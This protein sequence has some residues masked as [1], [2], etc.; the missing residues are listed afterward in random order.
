MAEGPLDNFTGGP[1]GQPDAARE[2]ADDEIEETEVAEDD[3]A[4]EEETP[5]APAE[6]AEEEP[7]DS[8]EQRI[9]DRFMED[10]LSEL[11]EEDRPAAKALAQ[12][13]F[14][15]AQ[16]PMAQ[17]N[18]ELRAKLAEAEKRAAAIPTPGKPEEAPEEIVIPDP[19]EDITG[20]LEAT[21]EKKLAPTRKELEELREFKR[22]ESR[23]IRVAEEHVA[24]QQVNPQMGDAES[25]EF[26]AFWVWVT[27]NPDKKAAWD[28][29]HLTLSDLYVL[30]AGK[31]AERQAESRVLR[32]LAKK[33]G[34]ATVAGSA[35]PVPKSPGKPTTLE[36]ELGRAYDQ[37]MRRKPGG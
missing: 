19:S 13:I 23:R 3:A 7:E 11:P 30:S 35:A 12:R 9:I 26:Q 10:P 29:G 16:M 20:W 2:V 8:E 21:V 37:E 25:P 34:A 14:T 28:A 6:E 1:L 32:K 27:Q 36:Q 5:E 4:V 31:E 15:K 24:L 17:E 22:T 33:R 18:K